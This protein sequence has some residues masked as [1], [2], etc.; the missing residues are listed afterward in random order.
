MSSAQ[1]SDSSSPTRELRDRLDPSHHEV[2][3][4]IDAWRL[5]HGLA[6]R[7]GTGSAL[8]AVYFYPEGS[9]ADNL[10]PFC[11]YQQGPS[12]CLDYEALREASPR[13]DRHLIRRIERALP[14]ALSEAGIKPSIPLEALREPEHLDAFLRE[15]T[16]AVEQMQEDS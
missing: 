14:G 7:K 12:F 13:L 9:E 1:P 2:F 10:G 15:L 3:D 8:A 11:L 6:E 5:R 4:A 16:W